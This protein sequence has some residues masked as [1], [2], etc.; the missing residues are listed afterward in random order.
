MMRCFGKFEDDRMCDLC[1]IVNQYEYNKCKGN[2]KI[3]LDLDKKLKEIEDN[4]PY[5]ESCWDE[6]DHFYGCTKKSPYC[7]RFTEECSV[8]LECEE[9]K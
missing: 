8:S 1:K 6:R 2:K 5:R 9:D 3:E 4:C 7:G